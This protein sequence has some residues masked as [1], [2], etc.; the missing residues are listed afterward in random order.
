MARFLKSAMPT[1]VFLYALATLTTMAGMEIFGWLLFAVTLCFFAI[2]RKSWRDQPLL[3]TADKVLL[4][5][6]AV[7]TL[8]AVLSPYQEI[9]RVF[10]IGNGRFVFLY[11]GIRLAIESLRPA[12]VVNGIKVLL[13]LVGLIAAYAISQ[14]FTGYD[15]VRSARFEAFS[16]S[17]YFRSGGMWGTAM[18]F[19][20]SMALSFFFPF[21]IALFGV[22]EKPW[23]RRI[24]IV[25][26]VVAGM[27]LVT[28]FTRGAWMGL[29]GGVIVVASYR[30]RKAALS[31]LLGL[32]A[33]VAAGS[34]ASTHFR[35]R[36][37]S[38]VSTEKS[39]NTTRI[40]L[41]KANLEMFKE[42][43]LFGVGYG[44]NEDLVAT[45]FQKM[46]IVQEFNGHAHNN[47]LQFLA[48]TGITGL[49]LFLAFSIL[50]FVMAHRLLKA[51]PNITNASSNSSDWSRVLAAAAMGGMVA[52]HIGGLTECNF[53]DA[54]V[55]H[56]YMLILALLTTAYRQNRRPQT[57]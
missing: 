38:I 35:E 44:V 8:S 52:L 31:T 9:D 28:S 34:F 21:S 45:Y 29:A 57:T 27:S 19:A 41:W 12:Q 6:F 46:G 1:L 20:H 47:Y 26:T 14:F 42:H 55:N 11:I 17:G 39:S 18:T 5:L 30:S 3:E 53:K 24:A 40:D 56:Q 2:D 10:V 13:P 7:I 51:T 32:I 23:V 33:L 50:M 48:G 37:V 22:P 43:P 4:A 25:V 54:E 49:A 15:L 36:L 16:A